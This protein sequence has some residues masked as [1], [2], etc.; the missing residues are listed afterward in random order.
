MKTL[1]VIAIAFICAFIASC[2]NTAKVQMANNII[3]IAAQFANKEGV[4]S[5]E[6]LKIVQDIQKS[7]ILPAATAPA[8]LL[9]TVTPDAKNP[10]PESVLPTIEVTSG[11]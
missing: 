2:T 4:I 7:V 9:P 5:D 1:F 8:V 3:S 11:K 6:Q 10:A